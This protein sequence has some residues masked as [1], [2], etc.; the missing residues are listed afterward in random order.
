MNLYLDFMNVVQGQW[1]GEL[2]P[3]MPRHDAII[4]L[5]LLESDLESLRIA[6]E[7]YLASQHKVNASMAAMAASHGKIAPVLSPGAANS[8]MFHNAKVFIVCMR[9]FA[10]LLEAAKSR[11]HEY[12][13][14]V[15]EAI[16]LTWK[17]TK[18]FFDD[19]RKARDAI[20]HIDGE[21]N[22]HNRKFINLL[23]DSLEVVDGKRA[24]ITPRALKTVERAWAGIVEVIMRPAE[25]R[26]RA[27]LMKHF[28][29]VLQARVECLNSLENAP[30]KANAADAKK[31]RG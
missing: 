18:S 12:P 8:R 11:K 28:L 20:E 25:A 6:L 14:D 29:L 2:L 15:G 26:V 21:V 13:Q 5:W 17:K 30:N 9:R 7:D 3:R 31:P 24:Y 4:R 27:I 22:G 23:G 16:A 19:Y 1:M 10:R